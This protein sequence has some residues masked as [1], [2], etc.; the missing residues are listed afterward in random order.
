MVLLLNFNEYAPYGN[1]RLRALRDAN[2][3]LACPSHTVI[4]SNANMQ[5]DT[6][7]ND[8]KVMSEDL[9]VLIRQSILIQS[10]S[11]LTDVCP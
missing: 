2:L 1:S 10:V 11:F 8:H 3:V 5:R 9:K 4:I 6:L 7:R